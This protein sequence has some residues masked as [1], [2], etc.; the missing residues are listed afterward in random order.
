M[1][2]TIAMLLFPD[3]DELDVAGPWEALAL[4]TVLRPDD[5][6]RMLTVGV[7]GTESVRCARGLVMTPQ[8]D[9]AGAGPMDVVIHPGGNGTTALM[10]DESH[11]AWLRAQAGRSE[12]LASVCTGALVLGAAGVLS[13]HKATTHWMNLEELAVIDP[14]IDV[15][16]DERFVDDGPVVTSAGV[17]AGIDMALHLVRRLGGLDRAQTVRRLMHYDPAPPV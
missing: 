10:H 14:T 13:H 9:R 3:V 5:G 6:W 12:I 16:D 7:T 17:S 11:L 15:R 4:W 8:V 1:P 2:K